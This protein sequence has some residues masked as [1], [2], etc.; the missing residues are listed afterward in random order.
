MT[1][2][3]EAQRPFCN[4]LMYDDEVIERLK[5]KGSGDQGHIVK[6]ERDASFSSSGTELR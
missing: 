3:R 6:G 2:P 5:Q 4:D 1:V